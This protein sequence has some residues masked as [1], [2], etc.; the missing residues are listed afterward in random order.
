MHR[1]HNAALTALVIAYAL[2]PMASQILTPAVP[3]VHRDFGVS[4]ATAQGLVS[5]AFAVIAAATLVY[6]PLSDRYGRRPVILAGTAL[7]CLGSLL[8]AAATVPGWMLLGRV[9]QA[10]GCAAGLTLTRTIIHDAYGRRRSARVFAHL[11]T[12]MMLVPMLAPGVGGIL[13]DH[14]GWRAVFGVCLLFGVVALSLLASWLPETHHERTRELRL[15]AAVENFAALLG[16]RRY[17]APAVFSSC[18]T[19]AIFATQA[20][21]PYLIVEVL[22]GSAT[23]YGVWFGVACLFYIAGNQFTARLG[24]RYAPR[25]LIQYSGIGCAVA[26]IAGAIAAHAFTLSSA[27][28]FVPTMGLYLFAGVGSAPVQNEALS[29]QPAQSGAASGLLSG[30]QMALGAATVQAIGH[31]HNGTP[32]PMF[33]IIIACAA[34]ALG[35]VAILCRAPQPM[36][37]RMPYP[38]R[39]AS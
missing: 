15:G 20:A 33:T 25:K 2:G 23:Q 10:A 35:A 11:T 26:A 18:M 22:G 4:M 21:I 30:M 34:A 17:L 24:Y 39:A 3:F 29:A 38:Q 5:L 1:L 31:S 7:F 9:L 19:G 27:L 32:Y 6:G 37:S 14:V 13:L 28:L 8:A 36:R 16:D 12:A